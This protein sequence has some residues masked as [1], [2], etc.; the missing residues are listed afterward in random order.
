MTSVRAIPISG[1]VS[2]PFLADQLAWLTARGVA[3]PWWLEALR[4]ETLP[5]F[6]VFGRDR[7]VPTQEFIEFRKA[8]MRLWNYAF[9]NR[10][11]R[12]IPEELEGLM[13]L[14]DYLYDEIDKV[15]PW[16]AGS[17]KL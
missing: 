2:A 13:H 17:A 6:G 11:Q 1:G 5:I 3:I 12:A 8:L 7:D 15:V 14:F 16:P 9:A 10:T 4:G